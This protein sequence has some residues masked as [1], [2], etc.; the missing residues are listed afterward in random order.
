MY[1][2]N[3]YCTY[4][5]LRY[6]TDTIFIFSFFSSF[7]FF[8]KFVHFTFQGSFTK[9]VIIIMVSSINTIFMINQ[10]LHASMQLLSYLSIFLTVFFC[11]CF[12][13][14]FVLGLGRVKCVNCCLWCAIPHIIVRALMS[15]HFNVFLKTIF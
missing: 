6:I 9:Y 10:Y 5:I 12:L 15:F 2:Y 4:D 1:L 7:F 14:L 8:P 3:I 11:V 13:C